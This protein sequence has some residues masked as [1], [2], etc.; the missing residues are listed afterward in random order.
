M[1]KS[2][3]ATEVSCAVEGLVDE[4]IS[5]RLVRECLLSAGP[6]YGRNGKQFLLDR[7]SGYNN[8][9]RFSPW[10]V[11]VDLDTDF[12]CAPPALQAWLP[13]PAPAMVLRVAVREAEAWLMADRDSF[14]AF[15]GVSGDR[16]PTAPELEV[17][18]K[19]TVV[20]LARQSRKRSI[21]E[22]MVPRASSG[23]NEGELYV[24]RV[25]QYVQ[26]HWRPRIAAQRAD[27]LRRCLER[28]D[29]LAHRV[30]EC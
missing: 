14:A 8:A 25:I 28:L 18:P 2:G 26:K 7:I 27:S 3:R 6:V 1:M 13:R 30:G 23:R 21:R 12:D 16:I 17:D 4:A 24:A 5:R 29:E 22:D 11:V 19:R 15:L 9:A 10:F 20:A